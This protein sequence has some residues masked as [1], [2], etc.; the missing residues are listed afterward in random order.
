M[1]ADDLIAFGKSFGVLSVHPFAPN[2]G[3]KPE[4]ITFRNDENKPPFGTDCWHSDETFR[5]APPMG[6]M[7]R[8]TDV[9]AFGAQEPGEGV[10]AMP[11]WDMSSPISTRLPEDQRIDW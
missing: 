4:L 8:A 3:V 9:P 5:I 6:T 11:D 2:S 1:S 7:L 10:D